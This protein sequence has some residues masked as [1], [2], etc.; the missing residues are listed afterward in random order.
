MP[1]N[2]LRCAYSDCRKTTDNKRAFG[3]VNILTGEHRLLYSTWLKSQHDG[4]VCNCHYT[5]LRRHLAKQQQERSVVRMA[6]LLAAPAVVDS[7]SS[8]E[9]SS[10][11]LMPPVLF[12]PIQVAR[13]SS[14]PVTV[15]PS[16]LPPPA[17]LV[18]STSMPLL[19]ANHRRCDARQR[20]RIAFACAMSGTTW[21]AYNRLEAN[22]NSH[23][24][25]KSTWYS[26]TQHVWKAIEAVKSNCETEYAQQLVA[27]GQPIVVMADG[28]WSHPGFTA[29]QHEWVLMN[30]A[31]KKAIFSIPLHRSRLREG[32]V[33]HQGNYD[34]G[35]S[36][37]MEGY[38]LDIALSKLQA[39]ELAPLISGW[40]GDQDSSVLKQLRQCL[41]AQR[42]EVHLDPGHAKKNLYKALQTMFG[43]K[44]A[45]D[46]LAARIPVFI[47]RLTKRAEKEHAG[48][49]ASMRVQFL[50]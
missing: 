13:S 9:S 31:D 2:A 21:T 46:G 20:K 3:H 50:K 19:S 33:V 28:A 11:A 48:S 41:A 23:S 49:V 6:Q 47:M 30:A 5:A 43:E 18:R 35:S 32:K 29:G 38:A 45:F 44:Q 34:D 10:P 7:T 42:W 8:V 37:G 26:L 27:A 1:R 25:N 16:V 36:K 12:S 22:L 40:V 14:L 39:T 24:L 4:V 15:P 17:A